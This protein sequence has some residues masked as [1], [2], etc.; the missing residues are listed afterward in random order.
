MGLQT[1]MKIRHE[2]WLG[3]AWICLDLRNFTQGLTRKARLVLFLSPG[4]VWRKSRR[5]GGSQRAVRLGSF[6]ESAESGV[7]M[8]ERLR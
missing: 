6:A 4:T 5:E 1:L 3:R 2:S 8:P 7:P